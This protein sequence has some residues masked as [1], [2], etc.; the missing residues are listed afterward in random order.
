M[1]EKFSLSMLFYK[2]NYDEF[3][4][5][6]KN[7]EFKDLEVGQMEYINLIKTLSGIKR[8]NEYKK[9]LIIRSDFFRADALYLNKYGIHY[10]LA[11]ERTR[12]K[13]KLVENVKEE[14][15]ISAGKKES[16]D[17]QIAVIDFY[18]EKAKEYKEDR[19]AEKG[20]ER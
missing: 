1:K 5:Y 8:I 17:K 3:L 16:V 11:S 12:G 14:L 15:E 20:H 13:P 18:Y 7:S 10:V 19:L 6:L 9:Y 2:K 4:G